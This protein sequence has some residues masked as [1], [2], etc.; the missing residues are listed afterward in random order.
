MP[1]LFTA[2]KRSLRQGN[3]FRSMCQ[4][5]CPGGVPAPKGGGCLLLGDVSA[6]GGCL[7]L[8]GACSRGRVPPPGGAG[9]CLLP[10]GSPGNPPVMATAAGSTHPTGMHSCFTLLTPTGLITADKPAVLIITDT[11]KYSS[12]IVPPAK[13]GNPLL[14]TAPPSLLVN[15][16]NHRQV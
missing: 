5:F 10:G 12:R 8:G 1:V 16:M 9:G 2:R 6:L 4:I 13:D 11:R 3:I 15:R 7:L 14:R